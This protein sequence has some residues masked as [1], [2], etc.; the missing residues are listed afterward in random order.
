MPECVPEL[1]TKAFPIS[2][3]QSL[4]SVSKDGHDARLK[5]IDVAA[6]SSRISTASFNAVLQQIESVFPAEFDDQLITHGL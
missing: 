5:D 2:G 6:A 3:T 1:L 4:W